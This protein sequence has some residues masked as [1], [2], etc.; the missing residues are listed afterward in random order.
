MVGLFGFGGLLGGGPV[1][2][3]GSASVAVD[4][5]GA[6]ADVVG[7]AVGDARRGA[8]TPVVPLMALVVVDEVGGVVRLP[9]VP[10]VRQSPAAG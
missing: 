10:P 2:F 5:G 9:S 4:V 3:E 1:R 7:A 6:V 8:M